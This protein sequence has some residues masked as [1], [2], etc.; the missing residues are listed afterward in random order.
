VNT[1]L[2]IV[3]DHADTLELHALE[4]SRHGFEVVTAE[5]GSAAITQAIAL[6]PAAVLMDI[7]MPGMDGCE[8]AIRIRVA[9]GNVPIV[10]V[11]STP[12]QLRAEERL[13]FL[14][15]F[16]KPCPAAAV[17]DTLKRAIQKS[18]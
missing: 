13:L 7:V 11:T 6:R 8:A 5:S 12:S 9:I 1:L 16:S 4:M 17:A 14:A 18:A 3:D 2:L 15:V 10:A